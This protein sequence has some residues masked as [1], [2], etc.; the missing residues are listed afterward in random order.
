MPSAVI[1]GKIHKFLGSLA[2]FLSTLAFLYCHCIFEPYI[3]A[4]LL[5]LTLYIFTFICINVLWIY[6]LEQ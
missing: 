1:S 2:D 6:N 4:Q 3:P 5:V